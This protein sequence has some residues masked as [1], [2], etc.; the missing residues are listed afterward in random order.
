ME[1]EH[2]NSQ[3]QLHSM[4]RLAHFSDL[5]I[6]YVPS[7]VCQANLLGRFKGSQELFLNMLRPQSN[8][9]GVLAMTKAHDG[10]WQRRQDYSTN[11]DRLPQLQTP[12]SEGMLGTK[13]MSAQKLMGCLVR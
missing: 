13:S 6:V 8:L 3:L 5:S 11:A 10:G 12:K 1:A 4:D 9:I 2:G 7:L